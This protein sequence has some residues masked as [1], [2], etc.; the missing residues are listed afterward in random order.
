MQNFQANNFPTLRSATQS[1]KK[2]E[3]AKKINQKNMRTRKDT[4]TYT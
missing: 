3:K 2:G 4:H 1:K